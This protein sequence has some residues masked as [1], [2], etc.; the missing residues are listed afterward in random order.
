MVKRNRDIEKDKYTLEGREGGR[1]NK[2]IQGVFLA[3][4]IDYDLRLILQYPWPREVLRYGCLQF[5]GCSNGLASG[6]AVIIRLQTS[7]K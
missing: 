3:P 6:V 2:G 4:E 5:H 7:D 1:W